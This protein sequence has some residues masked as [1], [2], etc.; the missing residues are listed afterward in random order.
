M[1]EYFI[2]AILLGTNDNHSHT[3]NI[4]NTELID[5]PVRI[6]NHNIYVMSGWYFTRGCDFEG[7]DYLGHNIFTIPYNAANGKKVFISR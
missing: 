1:N 2:V 6:K 4:G 5:N 3:S 7:Y